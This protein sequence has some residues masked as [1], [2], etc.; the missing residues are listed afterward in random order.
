MRGCR[1]Y[2]QETPQEEA[3]NDSNRRLD[4]KPRHRGDGDVSANLG[5]FRRRARDRRGHAG[6]RRLGRRRARPSEPD[7]D[8]PDPRWRGGVPPRSR[9]TGR[10]DRRDRGR[11]GRHRPHVLER[12][13]RP[14]PVSVR[15]PTRA[16]VRAPA[17]DDVRACPGRQDQPPRRATPASPGRD[18]RPPPRRRSAPRPP[19]PSPAS[20]G[21]GRRNRGMGACRVRPHLR[22]LTAVSGDA[23]P[24]DRLRT[25]RTIYP[26]R[27]A[28]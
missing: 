19:P 28:S 26:Q 4:R 23:A 14:G 12:R 9:A 13:R 21:E 15:D 24:P 1:R 22:R 3:A 10:N 7:G 20:G 25:L 16:G 8:V 17:G 18:R 5:G 2:Q 27:T 11:E 6:T